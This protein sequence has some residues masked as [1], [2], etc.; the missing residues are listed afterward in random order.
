[1]ALPKLET[2]TYELQLPSTGE[3]IK[4]RPF[5]VKEQKL[6]MMA[7]END[8]D[9]EMA[10]VMG[11]LVK[12]CTFDKIEPKYSPMFDIE[13]IFLNIRGKSVGE[14]V[15]LTVTC[16]DDEE[17]KVKVDLNIEDINVQISDDHTNKIEITDNISIV[18]RYPILD[19][20]ALL[21][22]ATEQKQMFSLLNNSILEIHD[23][24]VIHK[25]TDMS[26]KELSEF[27]DQLNTKQFEDVMNFFT[28]MPKLRHVIEVV[29]PKTKVTN[30]VILEGLAS[31]LG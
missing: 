3:K 31:F 28:T 24:D 26:K 29:N 2:P 18:L 12:A 6:L 22:G 14:I 20:V 19:D 4:Y 27:L 5:L 7:Q 1:M 23:G 13:Y 21:T 10:N 15:E 11:D 8:N 17:T 9:A 25:K 30:H 16:P